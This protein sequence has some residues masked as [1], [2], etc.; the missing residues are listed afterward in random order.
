MIASRCRNVNYGIHCGNQ[1][2]ASSNT[3]EPQMPQLYHTGFESETIQ[4]ACYR[5]AYTKMLTE[6]LLT[7]VKS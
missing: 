1:H 7:I 6:T 4:A 3:I 5:D 2:K